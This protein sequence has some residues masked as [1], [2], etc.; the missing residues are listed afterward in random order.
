MRRALVPG[1]R[2]DDGD[3][4]AFRQVC[5]MDAGLFLVQHTL[6]RAI[7]TTKDNKGK[8]A[9]VA[10]IMDTASDFNSAVRL[11]RQHAPDGPLLFLL[12]RD[13]TH[14]DFSFPFIHTHTFFFF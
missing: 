1:D 6:N 12:S 2:T 7:M 14:S 10:H 8:I 11:F 5:A 9:H 13:G 4:C 3:S